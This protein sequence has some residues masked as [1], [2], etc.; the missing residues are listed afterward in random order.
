MPTAVIFVWNHDLN[1]VVPFGAGVGNALR[2]L[3]YEVTLVNISDLDQ[4]RAALPLAGCDVA[5]SVGSPPLSIKVDDNWIFD[6]F[7][8]VFWFY[9]L[10]PIFYDIA[11]VPGTLEYVRASADST[12][13]KFLCP[14]GATNMILNQLAQGSS[15]YYPFA[16]FFTPYSGREPRLQRILVISTIGMELG[17]VAED[18]GWGDLVRMGN[19]A[20]K[21][22]YALEEITHFAEALGSPLD[23]M[24]ILNGRYGCDANDLLTMDMC[25]YLAALD[26]YQ[27]RRR[28]ILAVT[29]LKDFPIDIYGI[30]WE[31]YHSIF[32]N[33]RLLG[34]LQHQNI[35]DACTR[36][37]ALLNLDPNWDH[38]L[39]PR[40]YTALGHGCKVITNNSFTLAEL[41]DE[42]RAFVLAF[43]A[44]EPVLEMADLLDRAGPTG[45]QVLSFR[46]QNSYL[47]RTDRLLYDISRGMAEGQED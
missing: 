45:E 4:V 38:G 43:D 8:K 6:V 47:T 1:A 16:G 34:P 44:N 30:G 29:A 37:S 18:T 41:D 17:P 5:V 14:D 27:K 7:G 9:I 40:V 3:D 42:I 19:L 31:R 22:E 21:D 20:L 46:R 15:H 24:T 13:L 32:S 2:A 39:H 23:I 28:R 10:D 11:R 12:R 33:A 36:Y 35:G 25:R 26:S